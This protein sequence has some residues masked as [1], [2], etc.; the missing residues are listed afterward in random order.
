MRFINAALACGFAAAAATMVRFPDLLRLA[1]S[2]P[3]LT[4]RK[5][6]TLLLVA[7]HSLVAAQ[8][9]PDIVFSNVT[10]SP[11]NSN[12]TISFKSPDPGTCTTVFDSQKQYSGY[13]SLPPYTL[14]PIQQNY[15]I[16]TFFWF[17]EAREQPESAPL[18]VWWVLQRIGAKQAE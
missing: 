9:T 5:L 18:T 11:A 4:H 10:R 1:P 3:T 2:Q 14:A 8:T 6:R 17:I 16:N 12:I 15:S 13:I 7:F